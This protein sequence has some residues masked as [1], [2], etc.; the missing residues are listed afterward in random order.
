MAG[1]LVWL[2]LGRID[3]IA[4]R[5]T[6]GTARVTA[7]RH[8]SASY[9]LG[10]FGRSRKIRRATWTGLYIHGFFSDTPGQHQVHPELADIPDLGS[11]DEVVAYLETHPVDQVWIGLSLRHIDKIRRLVDALHTVTAEVRLI[12]DITSFRLLNHSIAQIDGIPVINMSVS[13]M[14]GVNRIIK[15]CEDK[16]LAALLLLALSPLLLLLALLVKCSSP[17]PVLYRQARVGWNGKVFD[18]FKFRSMPAEVEKDQPIVWGRAA[19]KQPT[20]IGR[21]LRKTSLDELPQLINVLKGEMSL[22]GPRPERPQFVEEFKHRIP[23]Y[24]QK[25]L[26]NAGMTGWAQINGWRGDTDL[27]K[28][29][30]YD[31]WYIE[32]WSLWLDLKILLLTVLGGFLDRHTEVLNLKDRS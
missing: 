19:Q 1:I 21:W 32:H 10:W 3:R 14:T 8:Q 15:W 9:R 6:F 22:V 20:T 11:L 26:V 23:S 12:L 13:P 30:E 16:I 18:M 17:G 4:P 5:R 31:L 29:I 27:H 24:M 7:A 25:H 28:R 2:G